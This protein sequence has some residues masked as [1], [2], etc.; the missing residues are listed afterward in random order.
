MPTPGSFEDP[1][2]AYNFRLEIQ[3]QIEG[4]FTEV[5]G[6]SARVEALQF[7]EGGSGRLVHRLPGRVD[8]GDVTLK[9][10]LTSSARLWD[11]MM[12]IASGSAVRKNVSIL[13]L[14]NEGSAEQVRWNLNQAFPTEWR[15][16]PLDALSQKVAIESMTLVFNTLDRA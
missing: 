11:W 9:Y 5:S 10:G 4:Y 16:T 15:G 6:L 7:R 8:Y 1:Y 14:N 2:R 13:L 12:T 3:G